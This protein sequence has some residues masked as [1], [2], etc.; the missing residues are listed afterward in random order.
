LMTQQ[1]D[2]AEAGQIMS[3]QLH[4]PDDRPPSPGARL[5]FAER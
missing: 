5:D 1:I 3:T 2:S 4:H